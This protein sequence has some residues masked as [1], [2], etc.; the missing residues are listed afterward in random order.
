MT[1]IVEFQQGRTV[2]MFVLQVYV[3]NFGLIR[4]V[5]ALFADV[6]LSKTESQSS[7]KEKIIIIVCRKKWRAARAGL[8]G[9]SRENGCQRERE[10]V[11]SILEC[12][13]V[14]ELTV[15]NRVPTYKFSLFMKI[16]QTGIFRVRWMFR[17]LQSCPSS[18][19]L[20]N[21]RATG[22]TH[23]SILYYRMIKRISWKLL[24]RWIF[25]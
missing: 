11:I 20:K 6:Y 4:R 13:A 5:A 2:R 7:A 12:A 22:Q 3:M 16:S 23:S 14:D 25:R 15:F 18:R 24:L 19:S 9:S 8:A 1:F 21:L 17:K 10:S